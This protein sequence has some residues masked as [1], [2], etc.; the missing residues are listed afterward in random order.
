MM[1][2][3]LRKVV[4]EVLSCFYLVDLQRFL[5]G[6][7]H[8]IR[9]NIQAPAVGCSG[10]AF[11]L[12][13]HDRRNQVETPHKRALRREMLEVISEIN[14]VIPFLCCLN[15]SCVTRAVRRYTYGVESSTRSAAPLCCSRSL[16]Y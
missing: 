10:L 13:E 2:A 9:F 15:I 16:Q 4:Y 14:L 11:D 5:E 6:R 7:G 12:R 1:F 3:N 8:L